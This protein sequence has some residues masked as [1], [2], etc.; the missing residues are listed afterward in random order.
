MEYEAETSTYLNELDDRKPLVVSIT[1]R[2]EELRLHN[3][4]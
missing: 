2:G 4:V 3:P 1:Q